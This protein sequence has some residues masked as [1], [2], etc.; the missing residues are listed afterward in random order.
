MRLLR[1]VKNLLYNTHKRTMTINEFML[2]ESA[3]IFRSPVTYTNKV[4]SLTIVKYTFVCSDEHRRTQ[5]F[6]MRG[7]TWWGAGP[8][9]WR[10]KPPISWSKMWS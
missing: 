10:T 3:P 8:A 9:V 6:T 5:D 4:R 7:F 1:D 2:V